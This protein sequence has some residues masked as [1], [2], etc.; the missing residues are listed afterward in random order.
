MREREHW[1]SACMVRG[2]WRSR[3]LKHYRERMNTN[4]A[5]ITFSHLRWNFV[6]QRP[7]HLLSRLAQT[8][9]VYFIEEPVSGAPSPRWQFS[10]PAP[11]VT[12]C[13]PVTPSAAPGFHDE[14]VPHLQS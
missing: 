12:V 2:R 14:Q 6:Y 1:L 8:Y 11:G 4:T 7:Q 3:S 10:E 9:P 5:I 13:Q